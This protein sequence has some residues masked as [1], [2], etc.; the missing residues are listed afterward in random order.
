MKGFVWIALLALAIT[1]AITVTGTILLLR[2][3]RKPE[4]E[5]KSDILKGEHLKNPKTEADWKEWDDDPWAHDEWE[6]KWDEWDE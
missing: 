5:R 3:A 1:A 4:N 6:R 2:Q